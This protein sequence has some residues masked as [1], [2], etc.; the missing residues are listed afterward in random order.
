MKRHSLLALI[1]ASCGEPRGATSAD[2]N[3]ECSPHGLAAEATPIEKQRAR[4]QAAR[5]TD[6]SLSDAGETAFWADVERSLEG[7]SG[8]TVDNALIAAV[9][10]IQSMRAVDAAVEGEPHPI[11]DARGAMFVSYDCGMYSGGA[12]LFLLGRQSGDKWGV[13]DSVAFAAGP[14]HSALVA[15]GGAA[16]AI[17]SASM[18]TKY[19]TSNLLL[20]RARDKR[21]VRVFARDELI[22]LR[23][24]ANRDSVVAAWSEAPRSFTHS[25]D[26][27]QLS[28]EVT[29]PLVRGQ[30]PS[31]VRSTTPSFQALDAFCRK[32]PRERR[33]PCG[34]H[35]WVTSSVQ[36]G[37]FAALRIEGARADIA[38]QG[39]SIGGFIVGDHATVVELREDRGRW[40]PVATRPADRGCAA[41]RTTLTRLD[42][43]AHSASRIVAR[44]SVRPAVALDGDAL[45]WTG[46][47]EAIIKTSAARFV[48]ALRDQ[49]LFI[50][51]EAG[52]TYWIS[53]E[54]GR[55]RSLAADEPAPVTLAEPD[56]GAAGLAVRDGTVY[57]SMYSEGEVWRYRN[58]RAEV[59]ATGLEMPM[60]IAVDGDSLLVATALG[61]MTIAPDGRVK[62]T[63]AK[64]LAPIAV[65]SRNGAL[66]WIEAGGR[67]M[68]ASEGGARVIA[69]RGW[70]TQLVI[71]G[72]DVF[73]VDASD[74]TV[75][76]ARLD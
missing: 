13:V 62:N 45:L 70:P 6:C 50:A 46:E 58:G 20:V 30:A 66:A 75:R 57:W 16:F 29:L 43:Q 8:P 42:N 18:G 23:I 64:A 60:G 24:S 38:C 26:G 61:I 9:G 56:L 5:A 17:E 51:A 69:D 32:H 44:A 2:V 71:L 12:R 19:K 33:V 4:S 36:S 67:V 10:A 48:R 37:P 65:A 25:I 76:A 74:R 31:P 15:S 59:F 35:D 53:A 73:W 21:W 49:P 11:D 55:L 54:T 22:D 72:S 39:E 47:E 68:A 1:F 34:P 27:P 14:A 28:F 52:T 41:T 40:T 63:D 7:L 3:A